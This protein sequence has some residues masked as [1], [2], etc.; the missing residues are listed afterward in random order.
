M[1]YQA[2]RGTNDILPGPLPNSPAFESHRWQWIESTFRDLAGLYGYGE[3]RTP[4]FED[5]ELFLR[6]SGETSD[7]VDKE[8]YEFLDRG[9]RELALKP[10]GTAPVMRAYL[11]H[12]QYAAGGIVR[13]WYLTQSFRY[14]RP[15]KGRYRQL[16]Q[17]G[18]ELIGSTSPR[19]DA[20]VIEV[21]DRFFSTIGLPHKIG[22][23][24]IGR[25]ESRGRFS[26]AILG[27]FA[28]WLLDQDDETR[29]KTTKN[30]FRLLDSKS[31]EIQQIAQEVP[32]IGDFLSDESKEHFAG[33]LGALEEA[34][35]AYEVDRSIVRGLD[36]YTDTVFEFVNTD[37][38]ETL[39]LCG[40]GRYDGLVAQLG[41]PPTPS[42]GVGIGVE[43]CLLT[44]SQLGHKI[45]EPRLTAYIIAASDD[46]WGPLQELAAELRAAGV[47]CQTDLDRAKLK[48]QFK[49]ADKSRALFALIL[50]D[51]EL[52]SNQVTV[53][54]LT[55]TEQVS[56]KRS[57]IVQWLKENI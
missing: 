50:G 3:V 25:P 15:G 17:L 48:G 40:G 39:S 45:P 33:V 34:G 54:N 32:D 31:P 35:V 55:T 30:P 53:K 9:G 12:K 7:V 22:V 51:D 20:E 18:L 46:A 21:T 6:S 44:L 42:V 13:Y 43:R 29:A 28:G 52:A 11:E 27:T 2:P 36:Y 38:G 16:H 5:K 10:E 37:F 49:Q 8:M 19:A 41:G 24:C 14:G 57:G 4:A 23:N 1:A 47:S 56:I 26:E